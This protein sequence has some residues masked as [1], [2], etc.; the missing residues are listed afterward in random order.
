MN[1]KAVKAALKDAAQYHREE[2]GTSLHMTQ[3]E[4]SELYKVYDGI[5]A[6]TGKSTISMEDFGEIFHLEDEMTLKTLFNIF[7]KDQSGTIE[8]KELISGLSFLCKGDLN[9]KIRF[10]F[11]LFDVDKS[12]ELDKSEIQKMHDY[13]KSSVQR[14]HLLHD[15]AEAKKQ[16]QGKTGDELVKLKLEEQR[17]KTRQSMAVI[18]NTKNDFVDEV[19][20]QADRDKDGTISFEEYSRWVHNDARA[21]AFV[22]GL[23]VITEQMIEAENIP[24]RLHR[25]Y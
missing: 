19:F 3:I 9:E 5:K 23:E 10:V 22:H 15:A 20:N 24:I 12:G 4:I 2:G 8:L 11:N 13:M 14:I 17:R 7:D 1:P 16:K 6:R 18:Q 21:R 25:S